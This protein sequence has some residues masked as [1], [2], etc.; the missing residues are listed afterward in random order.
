MKKRNTL[1]A[2]L[3]SLL[4]LGV[5]VGTTIAYLTDTAAPITN[6][7]T[8]GK[9]D[10]DLD[11]PNYENPDGTTK[12]YPG[13]EIEKDPTVT[14]FAGSEDSYVYMMLD[15][16]LN[17]DISLTPLVPAIT[18][19]LHADWEVVTTSGTKTLYRY[20]AVVPASATDTELTPLF[21]TV[22]VSTLVNSD[23]I[24][25]LNNGKLIIAA[26]AHQEAEVDKAVA[27][28]AAIAKLMTP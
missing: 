7:F 20:K 2:V 4:A 12:L 10:I 8:V 26:Y 5:I 19:D 11:E 14:V 23:N 3:G 6:T 9:I 27:D 15:N 1:I 13:A 24:N 18:L 21:T 28:A 17:F 16:Q 25:L 22:T